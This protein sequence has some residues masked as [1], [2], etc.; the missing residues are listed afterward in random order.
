VA[1]GCLAKSLLRTDIIAENG[2]RGHGYDEAEMV[3][4]FR[5]RD[6]LKAAAARTAKMAT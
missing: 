1:S 2:S 4:L 5:G 3:P 6:K